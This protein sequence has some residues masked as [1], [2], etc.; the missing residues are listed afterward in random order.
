MALLKYGLLV[1]L[2]VVL[3][4]FA[5]QYFECKKKGDASGKS[6]KCNFCSSVPVSILPIDEYYD[7]SG[8]E[9]FHYIEYGD[10]MSIRKVGMDKCN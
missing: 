2:L 3:G 7:L 9:C 10:R 1:V 5:M 6:Y 8:G 4:Y